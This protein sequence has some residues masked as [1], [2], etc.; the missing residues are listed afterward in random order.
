MISPKL[1]LAAAL[2]AALALAPATV[3]AAP[4]AQC[5]MSFPSG[6]LVGADISGSITLTPTPGDALGFQPAIELVLPPEV[7]YR[8]G[9][10]VYDVGGPLVASAPITVPPSGVVVNPYTGQQEDLVGQGLARPGDTYLLLRY[11]LSNLANSAPAARTTLTLA[12]TAIAAVGAP[13]Q[14]NARCLYLLGATPVND[15]AADP[16]LATATATSATVTPQL[17]RVDMFAANPRTGSHTVTGRTSPITFIVDVY[18]A[19][20]RTVQSLTVAQQVDPRLQ[21]VGTPAAPEAIAVAPASEPA[22]QGG[23]VSATWA[24]LTGPHSGPAAT[25]SFH[26]Y[27]AQFDDGNPAAPVLPPNGRIGAAIANQAAITTYTVGASVVNTPLWSNVASLVPH[28][29]LVAEDVSP[30]PSIPRTA[31]TVTEEILVSDYEAFAPRGAEGANTLHVELDSGIRYSGPTGAVTLPLTCDPGAVVPSTDVDALVTPPATAPSPTTLD[32][33]LPDLAGAGTDPGPGAVTTAC[34]VTLPTTI[35]ETYGD[36]GPPVYSSDVIPTRATLGTVVDDGGAALAA[37]QTEADSGLDESV[38]IRSFDLVKKL[39][40]GEQYVDPGEQLAW[41]ITGDVLGGATDASSITD[42]L[43]APIFDVTELGPSGPVGAVGSGAAVQL[44][45]STSPFMQTLG[46][47]YTTDALTN[48]ITFSIP[49]FPFQGASQRLGVLLTLTVQHKPADDRLTYVNLVAGTQHGTLTYRTSAAAAA[50]FAVNEPALAVYHGVTAA[51]A[52]VAPVFT[53][54]VPAYASQAP[55]PMYVWSSSALA[56]APVSS[57]VSGVDAGDALV[58]AAVL[59]N[60]GNAPAYAVAATVTVPDAYGVP[61]VVSLTDGAG[62]PIPGATAIVSGGTI[63]VQVPSIPPVDPSSGANVVVL[64]YGVPVLAG[65][66]AQE[67]LDPAVLALTQFTSVDAEGA[68]NFVGTPLTASANAT[69]HDLALAHGATWPSPSYPDPDRGPGQGAIGDVGRYTL[70][71]TVPEGTQRALTVNEVLPPGLMLVPGSL[72][73]AGDSDLGPGDISGG[74][75]ATTGAGGFSWTVGT[76]VNAHTD[77]VPRIL[78]IQYDAL[79]QNLATVTAVSPPGLSTAVATMG[80]PQTTSSPLPSPLSATAA[81]PVVVEPALTLTDSISPALPVPGGTT[82]TVQVTIRHATGSTTAARDVAYSLTLPS[83]S[84]SA[85]FAASFTQDPAGCDAPTVSGHTVSFACSRIAPGQV[86]VLSF[87]TTVP[88]SSTIDSQYALSAVASPP[89]LTWTS[90]PAATRVAG[91]FVART[92]SSSD[93]GGTANR[94]LAQDS[95]QIQVTPTAA[96]KTLVGGPTRTIGDWVDWDVAL[97]FPVGT[98]TAAMVDSL[99]TGLAF[100][101]GS[102]TAGFSNADPSI[103]SWTNG[104]GAA[105][106]APTL[107]SA[108]HTATWNLGTT[109]RLPGGSG[110]FSVRVQARV[111]DIAGTVSSGKILAVNSLTPP[112]GSPIVADQAITIVEPALQVTTT[113]PTTTADAGNTLTWTTTI[114]HGAGSTAPAYDVALHYVLSAKLTP[115]TTDLSGCSSGVNAAAAL[116]TSGGNTTVD[117]TMDQLPLS[118]TCVITWTTTLAPTVL[119]NETLSPPAGRTF[120]WRSLSHATAAGA[121]RT[122]SPAPAAPATIRVPNYV[123]RKTPTAA[124]NAEIGQAVTYQIAVD[125]PESDATVLTVTDK[126]PS[127]MEYVSSSLDF[128]AV[129][130]VCAPAACPSITPMLTGS[131]TTNRVA[132]WNFGSIANTTDGPTTAVKTFNINVTARIADDAINGTS[133]TTYTNQARANA[134]AYVNAGMVTLRQPT[135]AITLTPSATTADAGNTITWTAVLT[136]SAANA[137]AVAYDVL[138]HYVLPGHLDPGTGSVGTCTGGSNPAVTLTTSGG[139]TLVDLTLDS[140]AAGS[141]CTLTFTTPLDPAVQ[142]GEALAPGAGQSLRYRSQPHATAGGNERT[143]TATPAA[144][145]TIQVPGFGVHKTRTTAATAEIA[146]LVRYRITIDVPENGGTPLVVTDALP[147][148]MEFVSATLDF[149][150]AGNVVCSPGPCAGIAA[151]VTGTLGGATSR[152]ATWDFGSV[153]NTTAAPT[154]GTQSFTID[155]T[156]RIADIAANGT[157]L[158]SYTNPAQVN[159]GAPATAAAVALAQPSVAVSL[160]PSTTSADA[161]DTITWTAVLTGSSATSYDV[162]VQYAFPGDLTAGTGSV[163]SCSGGTSPSASITSSGGNTSVAL[164]L[165]SLALGSSCTFTFTTPLSP[166]V[167]AGEAL[168]P[169]S[170]SQRWRSQPDASALGAERTYAPAL[171]APAT[172]R[173][174]DFVVRK[175]RTSGATAAIGE[176]IHYRIAVD[177]PE[178]GGTPLIVTD[179]LPPGM[180]FVSGSLDFSAGNLAC[181]PGPCTGIAAGV[182]GTLGQTTNRVATWDFG[183]V[184]NTAG[185]AGLGVRTFNVDVTARIADITANGSPLTAYT[186]AA[187]ANAGAAV[188]APLVSLVQPSVS[189]TLT[190]STTTADAGDTISWTAVFGATAAANA[191]DLVA[192]FAFQGHLGPGAETSDTCTGGAASFTTSGGNTLVDLSAAS[193]A[194]G[195][196][197]T[198]V[199]TTPLDSGVQASEALAPAAGQT[200]GWRSQP[201]ATAGGTERTYAATPAAPATVRVPPLTVAKTRT[202][203]ADTGVSVGESLVYRVSIRVPEGRTPAVQLVDTLPTGLRFVSARYVNPASDVGCTPACAD[204]AAASAT[205]VGQAATFDL[206]QLT[207]GSTSAVPAMHTLALDVTALVDAVPGNVAGTSIG[208]NSAQVRS[209]LSGP[210]TAGSG[211]SLT[212]E[213]PALAV[214]SITTDAASPDAGNTVTFTAVLATP[215]GATHVATAAYDVALHAVLPGKLLP[216][217]ID[218]TGCPGATSTP[219]SQVIATAGADTVADLVLDTLVLPA[220]GCALRFRVLLGPDLAASETLGLDLGQS[221]FTYR[222]A[223]GAGRSYTAPVPAA[224]F[225]SA[226]LQLSSALV[227]APT[228]TIG[229][230]VLYD[231]S[232]AVPEGKTPVSLAETLPAGLVFRSATL[233]NPGGLTCA[234]AACADGTAFPPTTTSGN[235]LG[236]DLGTVTN[237]GSLPTTDRRTLTVRVAA[238]VADVAGNSGG[239]TLAQN[240]VTTAGLTSRA[241]GVLIVEPRLAAAVAASTAS[242]D[243]RDPV[244]FTVTLTQPGGTS[245]AYDVHLGYPLHAKLGTPAFDV[246]GCPAGVNVTTSGAG[247]IADF[248]MDRLP[249]GA[250][251]VLAFTTAPSD[252]VEAGESLAPPSAGTLTWNSSPASTSTPRAYSASPAPL[253][254]LRVPGLS[255]TKA[256]T[257][258]VD[259]A[260]SVGDTVVY[261]ISL[262]LPE[263]T[264]SGVSLTDTLPAGLRFVRALFVNPGDVACTPAC[265][266][267]SA[268]GASLA[269][270]VATFTLGT[271]AT[272]SNV[273]TSRTRT[274][275]L[276]LTALVDSV[277]GNT[278]GTV[279]GA[280]GGAAQSSLSGP[281]AAT[282]GDSL[283]VDEPALHVS[284]LTSDAASPDAGNSVTFTVTLASPSVAN[285]SPVAYGVNLHV[286]L[287]GVLRPGAIDLSGCPGATS[288]PASQTAVQV[289]NATVVDLVLDTLP[290]PVGSCALRFGVSLATEVVASETLSVDTSLA[291][292]W[293]RFSSAPVNGVSYTVAVPACG[294]AVAP[295]S[296]STGL[297]SASGV[298]VGG[299]VQYDLTVH[300][301]EGNAQVAIDETLPDGLVFRSA[302]LS[303]DASLS[304]APAA[305]SDGAALAPASAS[306][307]HLTLELGTVTNSGTA[308]TTVRR[309]LTVHVTAT[310]ANAAGNQAG[311]TLAA[312]S[313]SLDGGAPASAPG[314]EIVEPALSAAISLDPAGAVDAGDDVAV[315]TT[316][317]NAWSAFG[318]GA[319]DVDVAFD[320]PPE[321]RGRPGTITAS[322]GCALDDAQSSV[323]DSQLRIH[324][325]ELPAAP[326]I[327]TS[328]DCT[329]TAVVRP[330]DS[331]VFGQ[332]YSALATSALTWAS[333]AA[334]NPDRRDGSLATPLD[335]YRS[336]L[337]FDVAVSTATALSKD[338]VAGTSSSSLTADPFLAVG[339]TATYRVRV[340]LPEGT[341]P[342]VVVTDTPP[343]GLRILSVAMDPD[344]AQGCTAPTC[345]FRDPTATLDG[346]SGEARA[347]D[348]GTVVIPGTAAEGGT[349]SLLVTVQAVPDPGQVA[350]S[351]NVAGLA[352]GGTPTPSRASSPVSIVRGAPAV[353]LAVDDLAPRGGDV[354][355]VTAAVVN[356]GTGPACDPHLAI[357]LPSV[358]TV[359]PP[360]TLTLSLPPG[361]CL[362]AGGQQTLQLDARVADDVRPEAITVSATLGGYTSLPGGGTAYDPATDGFD[363]NGDGRADE[364]GDPTR[365]ATLL[366][367]APTLRFTKAATVTDGGPL[368]PG[369][370]LTYTLRVENSGTLAA[371]AV[372]LT[373]VLPLV[374]ADYEAGSASATQGTAGVAA[375]TLSAQLGDVAPGTPAEARVRLRV[376]DPVVTAD[377]ISNQ[378][379]LA[380]SDGYGGLSS[381]DPSTP[382]PDDATV[383]PVARDPACASDSDCLLSQWCDVDAQTCRTDLPHGAGACQ[384]GAPHAGAQCNCDPRLPASSCLPPGV[385][386]CDPHDDVCGLV[387]GS[388]CAGLGDAVCRS[389]VCNADGL[390]GDPDGAACD[391]SAS[392]NLTCRSGV[393][394]AGTRQCGVPQGETCQAARECRSKTCG[395]DGKCGD[396]NGTPC[397]DATACRSGVCN[398]DGHCGDPLGTACSTGATCRSNTCDAGRCVEPCTADDSCAAGF[399]CE[400]T[401]HLCRP[402]LGPGQACARSHGGRDCTAGACGADGLCGLGDGEA[403]TS[404]AECRGAS[405]AASRCSACSQDGDCTSDRYCESAGHTCT[406]RLENGADCAP[407]GAG[408]RLCRSGLCAQDGKCGTADGLACAS[409]AE[410]RSALCTGAGVC[411]A[412]GCSV[413]DDCRWDQYCDVTAG[414]CTA[415]LEN[416]AACDRAAV[417]ASAICYAGSCG[418][419]DREPC[420]VLA[421]SPQCRGTACNPADDA[422]GLTGGQACT[423][424][425]ECR[426]GIC[427][428]GDHQCGLP[429]GGACTGDDVCRSQTCFGG[430]CTL[431]TTDEACGPDAFC[432]YP[433]GQCAPRRA[434]KEPCDRGAQCTRNVCGQAGTC[435]GGFQ[436]G[437]G[438]SGS[439][440]SSAGET[441]VWLSLVAVWMLLIRARRRRRVEEA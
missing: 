362:A 63:T 189:I 60:A 160:T 285:L 363:S 411:A 233:A 316:V 252:A 90:V 3:R 410:C 424:P 56:A 124:S 275:A 357:T 73:L 108:N 162:L 388:P 400:P 278:A 230:T 376:K 64:R 71:I 295:L 440:C 330:A 351:A 78:R 35:L 237:P 88:A 408:N 44:D 434:P 80:A 2:A 84:L 297:A 259:T 4:T 10:A 327:G 207:P 147:P 179:T 334:P 375:G 333:T 403:C 270:Q 24:T 433:A 191:Y 307:Q 364:P 228:A 313:A 154:L 168:A 76:V 29:A 284:S 43:P 328:T 79:L 112:G 107:G 420:D 40:T 164:S 69:I 46:I 422:C 194:A 5:G 15:V 232:V 187:R 251:C 190:P 94:Y 401:A 196:S 345:T 310:V 324:L 253:A 128:S 223:P 396:L 146:E 214:T 326:A 343:R 241:Q 335:V 161:G 202:S 347:F 356:R 406:P 298:P 409:A 398:A 74:A 271:L 336:A 389:L 306:G 12:Q 404:P 137:A 311:A 192:H 378:A 360:G 319:H 26:G 283:V 227:S 42:F 34:H 226:P 140:L 129:N 75:P 133:V 85:P 281:A 242:V 318:A 220:S 183:T 387:N 397:T 151:G 348:L 149:S 379:T 212:V 407:G 33:V 148:G 82:L 184:A 155:V 441:P 427:D 193:L 323:T 37:A 276:D 341:S 279:I 245:D 93:P 332:T 72:A 167:Q 414:A 385:D 182:T 286:T 197:C 106:P 344:A 384:P 166:D 131:V 156:A 134:L 320:L 393:C 139:N 157:T 172:I 138:A 130:L 199:F 66:Q 118:R 101:P 150:S 402:A 48:S 418:A 20:G 421:P 38:H 371:R 282:S 70:A 125:V 383:V 159:G 8:A 186:N 329:V 229:D 50:A 173:V 386:A 303:T 380:T 392:P 95:T 225:T 77:G 372:V 263:G 27:V 198:F 266:D 218:L 188:N 7:T 248:R 354:V 204:G 417:C 174:P 249:L 340:T 377:A 120:R 200:L 231:L 87:Q 58:F 244:T 171:A 438:V 395:A 273:A 62:N 425:I 205:V 86:E 126:L 268:P 113:T 176:L 255:L 381:D 314:V 92:G 289:G 350:L 355:H 213:E 236:F 16:P 342:G 99:P 290:L 185:S 322:P 51:L 211:D 14:V 68:P 203:P 399:Y 262:A 1:G 431:C 145:A 292:S 123:V 9:S 294:F 49:P 215:S 201:H 208:A 163:G 83:S 272:T 293:L 339:E 423:A 127:G 209:T 102:E 221:A 175:T 210:F 121:E 224:S 110:A 144:P 415:R 260:V 53:P 195:A 222:S 280:N 181:T 305:C 47:T 41:Q 109:T 436:D 96:T 370:E 97:T 19:E 299:L 439:A 132:T 346:A 31:V 6:P 250:T 373:D 325:V 435:V 136:N 302:T 22:T 247:G 170:Q 117:I 246:S 413:D 57:S 165:A 349:L 429:P 274:L 143:T 352:V 365:A 104:G 122:Y 296:F 291:R 315:S 105:L 17:V 239:T 103:L 169:V 309:D 269:G 114:S 419:P 13:F 219:A 390:C 374:N 437:V 264:T 23:Q 67:V 240:V 30:D 217:S 359:V 158:F 116:G 338:F 135:V 98:T 52:G 277:P 337:A 261:R 111:E 142:A 11:P 89:V 55:G 369:G 428:E 430:V 54:T 353:T 267:G 366:P 21:L 257:S 426:V 65:V 32:L 115:G 367:V 368:R 432:D 234:P 59:E 300:V 235:S 405:C 287:P 100:V 178:N 394:D 153:A 301:P 312:N 391:P 317:S 45:P 36:G 254:T 91:A 206:G 39:Q 288:N 238:T 331:A 412:Q 265:A 119:A 256:R 141:S 321:L 216:G 361:T 416:G 18:V 61:S 304:C 382:A 152:V 308:A 28:G 358:L 81:G 177:V 25:I 258:P 180:E 243:A